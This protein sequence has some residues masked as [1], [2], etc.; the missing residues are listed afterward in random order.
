MYVYKIPKKMT[1]YN[2]EGQMVEEDQ[3]KWDFTNKTFERTINKNSG[4]S[5]SVKYSFVFNNDRITDIFYGDDTHYTFSYD[6]NNRLIKSTKGTTEFITTFSNDYKYQT[7]VENYETYSKTR[8]INYDD[9]GNIVKMIDSDNIFDAEY[10]K[11]NNTIKYVENDKVIFEK[12]NIKYDINDNIIYY[13][14][15]DAESNVTLQYDEDYPVTITFSDGYGGFQSLEIE[16]TNITKEEYE[17]VLE[18]RWSPFNFPYTVNQMT[19]EY[20]YDF[21]KPVN[22]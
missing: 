22:K 20:L 4:Y 5:D 11:Y 17:A 8:E 15:G 21:L 12:Q 7:T 14:G 6:S 9:N 19:T 18:L 1:L 16:Y 3:W 10:D 13:D 2:S